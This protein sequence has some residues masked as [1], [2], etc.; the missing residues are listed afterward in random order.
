MKWFF[1]INDFSNSLETYFQLIK[2]AVYT[3]KN[4]TSL[5]PFCIYDGTE[6]ELTKWLRRNNVNIIFQRTPHYEKLKNTLPRWFSTAAGA[7]LRVEIPKI[8]EKNCFG[9]EYVLYTDCDVMFLDNV[10]DYLR[11]LTCKYF[12]IGPQDNPNDWKEWV[13]TGVMYMNVI[14]LLKVHEEFNIYIDKNLSKLVT[15]SYDQGAYKQFFRG[16]WDRLDLTMNWKSYWKPNPE[17]KILHFHGPKPVETQLQQIENNQLPPDHTY[18]KMGLINNN[19]WHH[20]KLWQDV[21]QIVKNQKIDL[22][23]AVKKNLARYQNRLQEIKVDL[24]R[25]QS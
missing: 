19:F 8:I 17:T 5:E 3:A 18:Y 15:Q 1:A 14:N 7:F 24:K 2:V 9:D 22:V 23:T 10:E 4:N 16:Q 6:N 13:N 20:T 11:N 25:W 21:Y 12:A